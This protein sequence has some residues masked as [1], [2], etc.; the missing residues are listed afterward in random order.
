MY[1]T[2]TTR[3]PSSLFKRLNLQMQEHYVV[4][5]TCT[6]CDEAENTPTTAGTTSIQWCR[7]YLWVFN[8]PPLTLPMLE[9]DIDVVKAG[10]Y[11]K[12]C[13]IRGFSK[14]VHAACLERAV[15]ILRARL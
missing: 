12:T 15:E 1:A 14:G 10:I 3:D 8:S 2:G 4:C 9:G 6:P 13:S 11:S 5:F 7:Y